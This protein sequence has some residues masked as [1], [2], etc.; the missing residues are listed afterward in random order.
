MNRPLSL[1]KKNQMRL[2]YKNLAKRGICTECG[3]RKLAKSSC[4]LCSKCL[5]A[6]REQSAVKR[7]FHIKNGLCSNCNR[8]RF[9]NRTRCYVCIIKDRL[10]RLRRQEGMPEKEL[11]KAFQA[12]VKFK[13]RC[14]CCKSKYSGGWDWCID[15]DHKTKK[16][17]GIICTWCNSAIGHA[18]DSVLILKSIIKYLEKLA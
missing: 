17:R 3:C 9:K 11:E 15:H 8:P 14:E 6:A 10:S 13:G 18:K 4:A 1:H 2:R 7:I 16:F 12:L 5:K